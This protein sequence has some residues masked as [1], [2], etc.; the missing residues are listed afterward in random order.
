M[1]WEDVILLCIDVDETSGIA[2]VKDVR[3]RRSVCTS[4]FSFTSTTMMDRRCD[5]LLP[6]VGT[7]RINF[8]IHEPLDGLFPQRCHS[9]IVFDY[10]HDD[11]VIVD[12]SGIDVVFHSAFL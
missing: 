1:R 6:D 8:K 10:D 9:A 4:S 2:T 11:I 7:G 12:T 3:R 5:A